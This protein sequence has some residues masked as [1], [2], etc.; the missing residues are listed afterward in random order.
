MVARTD[1]LGEALFALGAAAVRMRERGLSLTAASTL[2]TLEQGGP[3][4][5]TELA[6]NEGV[7][8]PS[9]TAVVNQLEQLGLAERRGDPRDGRV[10]LVAVTRAGQR[11]LGTARR[12]GASLFAGLVAA[13]TGT[14]T[15]ALR[16]A[17]PALRRLVELSA[18][19]PSGAV[20]AAE[21]RSR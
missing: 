6:A 7:T 3:R 5:L 17:L 18:G 20:L 8:Q 4:R 14:E 9:M 15:R 13:L 12:D 19:A 10:V 11:Y 1:Q 16:S 21:R 2:S